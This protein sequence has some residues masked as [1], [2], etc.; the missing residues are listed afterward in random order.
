M[1]RLLTVAILCLLAACGGADVPVE[2][3]GQRAQRH[4]T[5]AAASYDLVVNRLYVAYYGRPADPDGMAFWSSQFA[6]AGVSNDLPAIVQAYATNATVK[7]IVDAFGNSAESTALYPGDNTAFVHAIYRNLFNRRAEAEGLAFWAS[8][9]D[10]NVV[11]RPLAALAIA[12]GAQGSD[13]SIIDNKVAVAANYTASLNTDELKKAY[14]GTRA[15]AMMRSMLF[16]VG[17]QTVASNLNS[18]INSLNT[19]LRSGQHYVISAIEP[20][21]AKVG[22]PTVFVMRGFGGGPWKRYQAD[23]LSATGVALPANTP[24]E[25][26]FACTPST[27]GTDDFYVTVNDVEVFRQKMTF[28]KA[29]TATPGG[30]TGD[31]GGGT[32][33]EPVPV[34]PTSTSDILSLGVYAQ[35][36]TVLLVKKDGTVWTWGDN[37]F[38]QA[39]LQPADGTAL[40][41]IPRLVEN[42]PANRTFIHASAG[43]TV[44]VVFDNNSSP[45]FWGSGQYGLTER[46]NTL[47]LARPALPNHS[48]ITY[49]DIRIGRDFAVGLTTKG[50]VYDWGEGVYLGRANE[51]KYDLKFVHLTF[52]YPTGQTRQIA[53]GAHHVV[54]LLNDGS[55]YTWGNRSDKGQLG[56]NVSD[57]RLEAIMKPTKVLSDVAFIAAGSYS[58]YAIKKDGT[59]WAWGA[60]NKGQLG[61]GTTVQR[62]APVGIAGK[63]S[64]IAPG[65][66]HVLALDHSGTAW[67]WG[68]NA[69][70]Q[71][72]NGS[73]TDAL[74]PKRVGGGY[75]RIA[76]GNNFSL[77]ETTTGTLMAAGLN[78][79]GQLGD[80]TTSNRSS[81]T[82]V[83]PLNKDNS[84][85]GSSANAT[86]KACA[87]VP[88]PGTGDVQFTVFDRIAQF[89]QCMFRATGS[90]A[91]VTDGNAQCKV[92]AGLLAM[93]PGPFKPLYCNGSLLIK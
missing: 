11:T 32:P 91:Y 70:G 53:V 89:D 69:Y 30:S 72:G 28:V 16:S 39:G 78:A 42:M 61:D 7:L 77:L 38:N 17:A 59:L 65:S 56:R 6:S 76:G 73:T 20:A 62:N 13:L 67:S 31:S 10:N 87:S 8:A 46:S 85:G 71:L 15:N 92:L 44:S 90:A 50:D 22:E 2:K 57:T 86:E 58:S 4:A 47:N 19:A 36:D 48:L 49:S 3:G 84:T 43:A 26:Y 81:L 75:Q 41:S 33:T 82:K 66:E 63:F 52:S 45:W 83:L 9:I 79:S 24:T 51:F 14:S 64:T 60:N 25:T 18:T 88:Y 37:S 12:V 74:V 68:S 27:E 93:A 5:V 21:T 35:S 23:C 34:T 40:W 55:V 29:G 1:K 54:T 80:G